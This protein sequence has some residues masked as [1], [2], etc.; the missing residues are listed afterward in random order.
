MAPL[1]LVRR[2]MDVLVQEASSH[3]ELGSFLSRVRDAVLTAN[4]TAP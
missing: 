2:Y 4:I 3:Y 1:N